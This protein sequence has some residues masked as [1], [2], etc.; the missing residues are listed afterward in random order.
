MHKDQEDQGA[1]TILGQGGQDQRLPREIRFFGKYF[2][3]GGKTEGTRVWLHRKI[4]FFSEIGLLYAETTSVLQKKN[5]K[6]VFTRNGVSFSPK[7]RRSLN[8]K[9]KKKVF[10]GYVVSF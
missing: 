5:K 2:G 6:R 7:I 4:R 9:K 3:Q 1:G 8:M 10:T